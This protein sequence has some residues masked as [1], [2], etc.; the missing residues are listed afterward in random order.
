M[1]EHE[2]LSRRLASAGVSNWGLGGTL[3]ELQFR[4]FG[5]AAAAMLWLTHGRCLRALGARPMEFCREIHRELSR[6]V[7]RLG[8][9]AQARAHQPVRPP[10]LVGQAA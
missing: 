2:R 7:W 8:R 6:F 4:L 1:A 9:T 10:E 5:L 3:W